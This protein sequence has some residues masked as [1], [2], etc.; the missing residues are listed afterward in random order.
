MCEAVLN[1]SFRNIKDDAPLNQFKIRCKFNIYTKYHFITSMNATWWLL[2][3][4]PL[5]RGVNQFNSYDV[6][7]IMFSICAHYILKNTRLFDFTDQGLKFKN[8]LELKIW[9]LENDAITTDPGLFHST[10]I[11][12]EVATVNTF[13]WC[14]Y[15]GFFLL[16]NYHKI[17]KKIKEETNF[18]RTKLNTCGSEED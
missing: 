2:S 10:I 6:W 18:E 13:D 14:I 3:F 12:K 15:R 5:S 7:R 4:S 17:D 8:Y 11:G 9:G 1:K 16:E